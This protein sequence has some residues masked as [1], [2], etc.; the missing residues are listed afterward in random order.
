MNDLCLLGSGTIKKSIDCNLLR[1]WR[2]VTVSWCH[3]ADM[4]VP[5]RAHKSLI[6]TPVGYP[7]TTRTSLS[8]TLAR[9]DK[10]N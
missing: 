9:R 2:G 10:T 6:P 5:V 1:S 3:G 4:D 8:G 7:H